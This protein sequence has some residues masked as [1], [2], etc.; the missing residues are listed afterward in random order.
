VVYYLLVKA[1]DKLLDPIRVLITHLDAPATLI[2]AMSA[3]VATDSTFPTNP[4]FSSVVAV[5]MFQK[6]FPGPSQ[7]FQATLAWR[8]GLARLEGAGGYIQPPGPCLD[9]HHDTTVWH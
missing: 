7:T 6:V 8:A 2:W 1:L 5:R 3:P 4:G 9:C